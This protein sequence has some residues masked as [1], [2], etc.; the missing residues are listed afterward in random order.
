MTDIQGCARLKRLE[1]LLVLLCCRCVE[2]GFS[3]LTRELI[4]TSDETTT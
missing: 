2:R 3:S 4:R 1:L